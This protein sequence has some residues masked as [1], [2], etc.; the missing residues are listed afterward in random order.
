MRHDFVLL[1]QR[2]NFA[3]DLDPRLESVLTAP[4]VVA[5]GLFSRNGRMQKIK[6]K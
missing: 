1:L 6:F 5:D 3:C 4:R 2:H